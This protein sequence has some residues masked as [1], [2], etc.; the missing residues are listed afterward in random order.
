MTRDM[1]HHHLL[2]WAAAGALVLA[3][4]IAGCGGGVGVGG[5]GAYASGPITGFGSIFVNG[6]EFEDRAAAV[7]DDDAGAAST[8][9][10]LRLG[11]VVE[12]ESGAIG[13]TSSAPTA[14]A[15]RIRYA[16]AIVGP[17][18]ANPGSGG[19]LQVFGQ[20]VAVSTTTVFDDRF[21]GGLAGV[22]V[23]SKVAVYGFYDA[24]SARYVATRI[25]PRPATLAAFRVRGAATAVDT[26]ARRFTLGTLRLDYSNAVPPS[27][28]ASGAL[29][30]VT[31]A[32]TPVDGVWRVLAFGDA[33][34]RLPEFDDVHLRGTVTAF[35][36]SRQFSID[37]QPVDASAAS[38]PDG[39]AGIVLGA[40]VEAEGSARDGV[41]R[42]TRVELDDGGLQTGF[43]LR[44][45]VE[46]SFPALQ[47]FV[48]RG[49]KVTYGAATQFD[50]G[51]PAL[52]QI[53]NEA[54]ARGVLSADGTRL[55]A[56]RIKVRVR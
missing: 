15:T 50:E 31:V 35:T 32:T 36:S 7:E 51:S 38:F 41:L 25:E 56:T 18:D 39:E 6:I 27:A 21:S 2:R 23:G 49:V 52:L 53:G 16:S 34:R 8:R 26:A 54:E 40:R 3:A 9:D 37:G 45:V 55:L 48:L 20:T 22:A 4:A 14:S 29:V 46:A 11:M 43:E 44:G 17:V 10:A 24:E 30:R 19:T 28:L 33:V 12:V 13:G 42:A 5:T 47:T 1:L